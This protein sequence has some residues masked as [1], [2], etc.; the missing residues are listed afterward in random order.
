MAFAR[1]KDSTYIVDNSAWARFPKLGAAE[2]SELRDAL[3]WRRALVSSAVKFEYLYSAQSRADF[4]TVETQIASM[5]ELRLK[6]GVV[7]AAV[8]ALRDLAAIADGYHRVKPIDVL[9]AATA[10]ENQVGV[11]HYDEHYDRLAEVLTF[12]SYWLADR[13]TLD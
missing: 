10:Q 11:L 3:R 1:W 13:G 9:V 7:D 12:E 4:E 5:R 6:Q 8:G 2:A